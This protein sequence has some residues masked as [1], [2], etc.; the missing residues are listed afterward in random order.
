MNLAAS[1]A[2]ALF[3]GS[4][5]MAQEAV[6][7]TDELFTLP[8]VIAEFEGQSDAEFVTAPTL[9]MFEVKSRDVGGDTP[10]GNSWNAKIDMDLPAVS[11]TEVEAFY[12]DECPV[13][14]DT[15]A[16]LN[17]LEQVSVARTGL[18][19][20]ELIAPDGRRLMLLVAGG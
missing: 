10:C 17:A 15:I 12:S 4:T 2:C 18:D 16:L 20:L 11:I 19:G 5:A 7:L 14:R 13:Y 3:L 9:S 1:G 8:W 6:K